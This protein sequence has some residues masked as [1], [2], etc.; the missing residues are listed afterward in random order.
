MDTYTAPPDGW[1]CFFCGERFKK[2]GPAA[3]HFGAEPTDKP[4]C[5]LKVEV[6]NERGLLMELRKAQAEVRRLKGE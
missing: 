2:A 6:G 4:G 1:V 3:D 5:F